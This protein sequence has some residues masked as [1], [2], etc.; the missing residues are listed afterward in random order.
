MEIEMTRVLHDI[1]KLLLI[2]GSM[3]ALVACGG[4]GG[5]G[6]LGPVFDPNVAPQN[7]Q[8]V[9]GTGGIS[10]PQNTISWNPVT[11]ATDYVVYWDD[12]PGVTA[13]SD[14]LVPVPA[15]RPQARP[16]RS[17]VT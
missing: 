1:L 15:S 9:A 13:N 2:A 5:G 4:G 8:A 14:V 10:G 16:M 12:A 17:S 11:A 7:A 6:S 3:A